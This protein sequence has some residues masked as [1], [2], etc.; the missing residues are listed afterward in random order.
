MVIRGSIFV[1]QA[2]LTSEW[3]STEKLRKERSA[4]V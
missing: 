1:G 3:D 2:S 4:I